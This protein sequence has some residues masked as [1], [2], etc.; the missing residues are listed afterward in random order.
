MRTATFFAVVWIAQYVA[1]QLGDHWIQSDRQ[2]C[3]KG[4][5]GWRGRIACTLHVATYLATTLALLDL[6][7]LRLDLPID[8]I[9]L[10]AGLAISGVTHW[11]LDRRWPLIWLA[12]R[13]GSR[14]FVRLG[15]PRAGHDD[16]PCLGTGRYALDQSAHIAAIFLASLV[17]A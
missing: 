9:R 1:H 17:I 15:T 5:A 16:K 8:P 13:T 4:A 10:A 12:D 7:A 3:L 6:T 11:V 2:A 14:A